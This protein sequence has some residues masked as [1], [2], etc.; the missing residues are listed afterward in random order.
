MDRAAL[1]Q[2]TGR[3]IRVI[4]QHCVAV[5]Y[6]EIGRAMYDARSSAT[7]LGSIQTRR[8]RGSAPLPTTRYASGDEVGYAAV[9][10]RLRRGFGN[11]R[12]HQCVE[13]GNAAEDWAYD[14]QDA[15][16]RRDSR[17]LPYSVRPEHY[18][19]MCRRCHLEFDRHAVTI[20]A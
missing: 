13:C 17:G 14:H 5:E 2:W 15:D 19:P 16:E 3:S 9:H 12:T 7:L 8:P 18:R 1:A 6:D 4:R 20:S 11:A 10:A